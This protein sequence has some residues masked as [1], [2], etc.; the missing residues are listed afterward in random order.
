[1]CKDWF[2]G[3]GM[4]Y[5][6]NTLGL[7]DELV[8]YFDIDYDKDDRYR[9]IIKGLNNIISV[10]ECI[11]LGNLRIKIEDYI[12]DLDIVNLKENIYKSL[13]P[14][15]DITLIDEEMLEDLDLG[16]LDDKLLVNYLIKI[17]KTVT[18][19][20]KGNLLVLKYSNNVWYTGWHRLAY[21]CRGKVIDIDTKEVISYPFNKFFN[22]NEIEETSIKNIKKLIRDADYVNITDKIDGTCIIVTKYRGEVIINTNGSFD[23]IQISMAK[24]LFNVKY[25]YFYKN[26][27]EGYTF[28]FELVHPDNRIIIDYK[29]KKMLY[30]LDVR[31]LKDYRLLTYRELK[32]IADKYKLD[33]VNKYNN[34]KLEDI[35]EIAE[36]SE[37]VDREGWVVNIV[38]GKETYLLKVKLSEY[39]KLAKIR[40]VINIKSIYKLMLEEKLDD[41][42]SVLGEEEKV[43]VYGVVKDIQDIFYYFKK[44]LVLELENIEKVYGVGPDNFSD[45]RERMIE[46]I[47]VVKGHIFE[48]YLF[49]VLKQKSDVE[50]AFD[51][52]P[53][54][55]KFEDL[56]NYINIRWKL[57]G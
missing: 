53:R 33:L 55:G 3:I 5:I 40:D 52:L 47:K 15:V 7:F 50:N 32:K 6:L 41:F 45:D 24:D 57:Y 22:I 18:W 49:N 23:S 2:G 35:L 54:L 11:E 26:I 30:L 12:Y 31:D 8:N 25:Q 38:K 56:V 20:Q 13:N 19:N 43:L 29:D 10:D 34:L 4:K 9:S 14:D 1:M 48:K 36:N 17:L 27:P 42:I 21:G 39:F 16:D 28:I 51:K 44:D 37:D 46:V